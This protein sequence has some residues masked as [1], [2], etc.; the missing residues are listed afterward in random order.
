M[1]IYIYVYMCCMIHT[2]THTHIRDAA[3][4]LRSM[5]VSAENAA[6]PRST[7]SG[8]SNS[9]VQIQIQSKS[10]FECVPRDIEESEFLDFGD[11]AFS[12]ETAIARPICVS[13]SRFSI[14][15][16]VHI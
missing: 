12:V 11:V 13:F 16:Y 14:Y 8:N 6:P 10:Q 2:Q 9:S 15:I 3:D 4:V 1:Y 5:A 7:R